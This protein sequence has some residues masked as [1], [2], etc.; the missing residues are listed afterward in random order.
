M[1][2]R[3]ELRK[4]QRSFNSELG[5]SYSSLGSD[6]NEHMAR[7]THAMA[8]GLASDDHQEGVASFLKRRKPK[9]TG[10]YRHLMLNVFRTN[11]QR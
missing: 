2:W 7:H 6:V 10:T 1:R 11:S 9:F 8:E 5:P 4:T 3:V